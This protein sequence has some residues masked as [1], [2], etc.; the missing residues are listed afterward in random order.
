MRVAR[1][2]VD[3]E[4]WE[5][6]VVTVCQ[7]YWQYSIANMSSPLGTVVIVPTKIISCGGL[8]K[9]QNFLFYHVKYYFVIENMFDK[10]ITIFIAV[11]TTKAKLLWE[12]M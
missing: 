10:I 4:K 7:H 11:H 8:E 1:C 3:E 6:D 2:Q 12:A 9:L 5:D